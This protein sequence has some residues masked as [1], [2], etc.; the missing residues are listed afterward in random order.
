LT[1]RGPNALEQFEAVY[2]SHPVPRGLA[3]LTLL[4]LIFDKVYFPGVYM[5]SAFDEK[6]VEN[7]IR[8][9]VNLNT[10]DPNTHQVINCMEFALHHKH[11]DFCIFPG[12]PGMIERF[13][14]KV[15]E[16]VD[17]LEEMVFGPRPEGFIPDRVVG[18]WVKGLPGDDPALCQISAPDTITY[19]ANALLFAGNRGLPLINDVEG[20][21]VPG[22]AGDAKAN[23][24]LLATIL[25][26]ESVKLVLPNIRPLSP[27]DLKDFREEL[28]PH[29]RPFR[30][31]MLK[32]A[33][34]LNASIQS[35]TP[36][37]ELSRHAKFLVDTDVYP[38]LSELES[39]INEPGKPWYR[40]AVDLVKDAPE[41]AA[42]FA[43]LPLHL[44]LA[45][46]IAKFATVL[47][48]TRD[49]QREKDQ[50]VKSGL[51]YLLKIKGSH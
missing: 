28:A 5:P 45:K 13:D 44:S 3:P 11:L 39:V 47:A 25:A 2:Y 40:R 51:Y 46:V 23:A 32:L 36:V 9:L 20:L 31:S 16:I 26:I 49:E 1:N 24:K 48:D 19:P 15:H 10:R 33:K 50:L 8:R 29:V 14:P 37:E 22:I 42:N 43:T 17:K 4:G 35:G 7:E 6:G 30:L 38:R 27:E 18:P 12:K 41:L 21:P 34:D